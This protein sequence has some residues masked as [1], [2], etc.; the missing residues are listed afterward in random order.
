MFT[1]N[2]KIRKIFII[3]LSS[4]AIGMLAAS[5][6]L[7]TFPG[8]ESSTVTNLTCS[9]ESNIDYSVTMTE[10]PVYDE[11]VIS[12]EKYYLKPFTVNVHLDCTLD[13]VTDVEAEI[14]CSGKVYGVL[15][16]EIANDDS[17]DIVWEKYYEYVDIEQIN[18][19]G[20]SAELN[21]QVTVDLD[22]YEAITDSLI[23]DYYILTD[24]Y[25]K[26]FLKM[27]LQFRKAKNQK[28]K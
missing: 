9:G 2:K 18:V 28:Q 23:N 26:I 13:V 16:S 17:K 21:Q 4:L 8:Y 12:D 3:A 22:E 11:Q 24:Y 10:N 6:L 27:K 1:I 25:L 19:T 15:I 20:Q 5:I 7:Y 14:E